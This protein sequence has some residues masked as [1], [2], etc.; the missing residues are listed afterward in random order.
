MLLREYLLLNLGRLAPEAVRTWQNDMIARRQVDATRDLLAFWRTEVEGRQ[1]LVALPVISLRRFM[2]TL[3]VADVAAG[4]LE[5]AGQAF[6]EYDLATEPSAVGEGL[7][8]GGRSLCTLTVEAHGDVAAGRLALDVATLQ[9]LSGREV[10]RSALS[11]AVAYYFEQR[12]GYAAA[13]QHPVARE[14]SFRPIGG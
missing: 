1:A 3:P 8:C 14:E 5:A 2:R 13:A 6:A 7:S 11:H 12:F 9:E 10:D 4:M